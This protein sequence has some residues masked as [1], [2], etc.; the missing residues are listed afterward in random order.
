MLKTPPW[1]IKKPKVILELAELDKIKTYPSTHQD[2]FHN[3]IED[4]P[5]DY[6]SLHMAPRTMLKH[7]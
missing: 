6:T 1:I 7:V 5:N 3:I 4:N 2:K